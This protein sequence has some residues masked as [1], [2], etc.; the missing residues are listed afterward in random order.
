MPGPESKSR[1]LLYGAY[2]YTGRLTARLAAERKL[3]VVLAG[4]NQA[5]LAE[6]GARLGLPTRAVGLDDPGQLAEALGDV[7]CVVHMAGPFA[8]TSA[9]MLD[10]CLATRTNYV[11]ITGEIE[12]FE[13]IW[14]RAAEIERAGITVVPGAG[15]DVVPTDCLAAYV[16]SRSDRPTALVLALRGLE[17]ASR[18]TLRTAIGQISKPV[19]C[20][21]S[22]AIVALEDRSPRWI[23][24]GAG[25]EP[26][27]PVSW[28]DVATAFH[29]TGAGDVTVYFRRTPLL[30]AADTLGRLFGPVLRSRIGQSALAAFV[31]RFPEGPSE[32]ERVRHRATIWAEAIDSSSRAVRALLTTPDPYDFTAN[33]ALEIAARISSLPAARGLATPAQAFG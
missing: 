19:L 16:A 5:A 23:D 15:F 33:C 29:T 2:G 13:A 22:G 12:V 6:M 31:R 18:G 24:F 10:A 7:A 8:T 28:G 30:R 20:R 3:D 14:S 26:C 9:P 32:A 4:R 11:D 1:L 25:A 27:V 21:R 17:S